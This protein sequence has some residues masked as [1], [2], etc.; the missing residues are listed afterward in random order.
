MTLECLKN[1]NQ[2]SYC[3][4]FCSRSG[5]QNPDSWSRSCRLFYDL[6]LSI[7]ISSSLWHSLSS[8]IPRTLTLAH[9]VTCTS[10]TMLPLRVFCHVMCM[11]VFSHHVLCS[12]CY[13]QDECSTCVSTCTISSTCVSACHRGSTCV[14]TCNMHPRCLAWCYVCPA[15]WRECYTWQNTCYVYNTRHTK[16]V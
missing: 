2:N 11:Y 9:H 1:C 13:L 6:D 14:S 15:F 7:D 8:L 5:L 4:C 10:L 3:M 16:S 12:A